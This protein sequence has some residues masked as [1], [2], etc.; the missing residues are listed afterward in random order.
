MVIYDTFIKTRIPKK[1]YLLIEKESKKQHMSISKFVSKKLVEAMNMTYI[2]E[3]IVLKK[4][5]WLK[6][7]II[8]WLKE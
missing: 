4:K 6:H 7:K 5:S 3:K 2:E 8:Q 1:L